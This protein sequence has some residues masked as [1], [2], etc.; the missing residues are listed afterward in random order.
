ME[1]GT[2]GYFAYVPWGVTEINARVA[3][4]LARSLR[5]PSA[6]A[7]WGTRLPEARQRLQHCTD[8]VL[9]RLTTT[10]AWSPV[11]DTHEPR[12]VRTDSTVMSLWAL[13]EI[14]RVAPSD[15]LKQP[16]QDGLRW[17]LTNAD[18]QTGGWRPSPFQRNKLE[19]FPG[20]A[21]KAIYVL[22]LAVPDHKA[23]LVDGGF[24]DILTAF[25]HWL[26]GEEIPPRQLSFTTR[27]LSDNDRM[28][29]AD[30]YLYRSPRML[31]G[32]THLWFAWAALACKARER[33][34]DQFPDVKTFPGCGRLAVRVNEAVQ[35]V[36]SETSSY[37]AS[38]NLLALDAI[39]EL[40]LPPR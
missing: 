32:T 18:M 25:D 38:E 1:Q 16:I 39:A 23:L 7:L 37:V 11:N 21:A 35:F 4:A 36:T 14:Q 6:A 8:L 30:R 13:L 10:G 15:A 3:L 9:A 29:D 24:G 19:G 26:A 34:A 33:D 28:H 2:R 27:S 31:E 17:M 40:S 12:F 22:L 5:H 20:L